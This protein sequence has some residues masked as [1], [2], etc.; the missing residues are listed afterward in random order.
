MKGALLR[1]ISALALALAFS[2]C[3]MAG[4]EQ[5]STSANG[6]LHLPSRITF[7][8]WN[9]Q[10]GQDKKLPAALREAVEQH[11]PHLVFLQ[12]A[13]EDIWE[14][15]GS[16][17]VFA[18]SWK[19]PWPGSSTVGVLTAA[20]VPPIDAHS[21]PT[22]HREL[23]VTAPKVSLAS[24]YPLANGQTLLA[25]NVHCLNFERWGTH[26]LQTQLQDLKRA[27]YRHEGP[28]LLAGDFNTWS[29]KR[30]T[31]VRKVTEELGLRELVNLP[32][33]VKTGDQGGEGLNRFLGIDP[34]LPLDR[35]FYR[36]LLVESAD[37]LD[38][39]VSDHK[40]IVATF[41]VMGS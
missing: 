28:M 27:M 31:L 5:V 16:V 20:T 23:F 21:L 8:N 34:T 32:G 7:L 39:E 6:L 26:K 4:T 33:S 38:Y 22:L 19:Y 10:K 25:V 35:I 15:H 17:G 13:T 12:E 2:S 24:R 11:N 14:G 18:R 36:G 29:A 40:A 1:S 37:V 9:A 3:R 30:Y 41:A